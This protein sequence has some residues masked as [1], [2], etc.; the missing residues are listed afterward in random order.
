MQ[1][2]HYLTGQGRDLYQD[3]LDGLRDQTARKAITRRMLRLAIGHFGDHKACRDGVWEMR[4]DVGPG[5]RVY[6]ALSGS[7]VVLLFCGGDKST[8][9]RDIE[10]AARCWIDWKRRRT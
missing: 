3:W 1:I 8:Q 6:Y 9:K 5:Y 4:I 10:F 2:I 7:D